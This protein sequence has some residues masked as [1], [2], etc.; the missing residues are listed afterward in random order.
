MRTDTYSVQFLF[1]YALALVNL[2]EMRAEVLC[3]FLIPVF[4]LAVRSNAI[5][6]QS[7]WLRQ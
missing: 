3:Y 5:V 1:L 2:R 4:A 6:I 7:K